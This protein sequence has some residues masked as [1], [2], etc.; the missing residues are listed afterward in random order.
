[1]PIVAKAPDSS[2]EPC[3]EGLHPAVCVDVIDLG[4]QQTPWGDKFQIQ[5]RFQIDELNSKGKRYEIRK[6]Y[7]NSLSEKANLRRD[8]EAWRG[9][10]FSADEL[11]TGFDVERLINVNC[12]INVVHDLS[13][14]GNTYAK[15]AGIVPPAKNSVKLVAQDYT[16]EQDRPT[17]KHVGAAGAAKAKAEEEKVPF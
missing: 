8:L 9:K 12:Q 10:P 2:F 4:L 16:R 15:V 7:T 6:T 13:D 11:R 14:S 5:L 1:M 3:P 17:Q